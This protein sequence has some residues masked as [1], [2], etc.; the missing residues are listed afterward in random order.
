M[1]D[2]GLRKIKYMETLSKGVEDCEQLFQV[3][4][5]LVCVRSI[6]RTGFPASK[7]LFQV[8]VCRMDILFPRIHQSPN[9]AYR[10]QTVNLHEN[11]PQQA[12]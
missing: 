12:E 1:S 4:G 11:L 9:S 3:E 10:L 2:V 6:R 8:N 5:E 7:N